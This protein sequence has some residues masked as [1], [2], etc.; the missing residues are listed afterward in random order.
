MNVLMYKRM[1]DL[2]VTRNLT[3]V[4]NEIVLYQV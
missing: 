2:S 4:K 3:G 1:K